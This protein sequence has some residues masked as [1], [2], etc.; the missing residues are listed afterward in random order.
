MNEYLNNFNTGKSLDLAGS[1][2]SLV[3]RLGLSRVPKCGPLV[4][5]PSEQLQKI[6]TTPPK[7]KWDFER[8]PRFLR[9]NWIR[10]IEEKKRKILCRR[11]RWRGSFCCRRRRS[12]YGG[13]GGLWR[14]RPILS[15]RCFRFLADHLHQSPWKWSEE[16]T[17]VSQCR[18][19]EKKWW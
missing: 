16:E 7:K 17:W 13:A 9:T 3:L 5:T 18:K 2:L 11:Q 12:E 6:T 1:V 4:P 19:R 8:Y 10:K 15:L 14:G